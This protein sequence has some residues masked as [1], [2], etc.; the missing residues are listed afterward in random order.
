MYRIDSNP[1]PPYLFFSICQEITSHL[2]EKGQ[3][4][5]D[6]ARQFWDADF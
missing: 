6:V 3:R 4:G 2:N 5:D 1:A